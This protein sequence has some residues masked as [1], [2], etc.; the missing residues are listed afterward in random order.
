MMAAITS[1]SACK[2]LATRPST[3]HAVVLQLC[4]TAYESFESTM[5][6]V[7]CFSLLDLTS[8]WICGALVP[9]LIVIRCL[10]LFTS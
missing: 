2:V 1:G 5:I 7:I 9:V 3:E 4:A 8:A 10:A 6:G